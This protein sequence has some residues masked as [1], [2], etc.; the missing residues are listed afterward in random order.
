VQFYYKYHILRFQVFS[1]LLENNDSQQYAVGLLQLKNTE[2]RYHK[3]SG[4]GDDSANGLDVGTKKPS[5]IIQ[6][7]ESPANCHCRIKSFLRH[8][9]GFL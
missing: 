5:R 7:L 8:A 9:L 4:T 1:L 6:A 2:K 3:G